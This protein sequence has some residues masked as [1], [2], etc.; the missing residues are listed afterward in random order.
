[1][2]CSYLYFIATCFG[3]FVSKHFSVIYISE[4]TF[5]IEIPHYLY[6]LYHL[7]RHFNTRIHK[8]INYMYRNKS[9]TYLK[10][11]NQTFWW[12]SFV[13]VVGFLI[14]TF[15]I[16][17]FNFFPKLQLYKNKQEII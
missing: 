13:L 3:Q 17:V 10:G 15:F 14:H 5:Y 12:S 16:I 11:K 8:Y 7:A 6:K 4:N 9:C 2:Q 1:M